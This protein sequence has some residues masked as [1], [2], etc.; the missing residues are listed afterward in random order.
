MRI[1]REMEGEMEGEMKGEMEGE[2]E[3]AGG[4]WSWSVEG[5]GRG[6][7]SIASPDAA[8]RAKGTA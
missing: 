3:G 8:L 6:G 7:R 2:L 4:S 5:G 1:W